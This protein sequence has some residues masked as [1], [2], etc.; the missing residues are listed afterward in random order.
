MLE[1]AGIE[2]V[3]HARDGAAALAEIVARSP[4]VAVL[5]V[6]MPKHSGIEIAKHVSATHPSTAVLLYTGYAERAMVT[7]ALDSGTRGF[8][9]KEAP[10]HDLVRAV[11]T[12]ARGDTYVDAVLAGVI[13]GA[14]DRIPSLSPREREI[15]RLLS[16]GRSNSEVG[17]ELTIST[18]TVRTHVRRAM[19]KLESNTRTQAVATA[20]RLAIIT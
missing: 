8:A 10:L 16:N 6:R 12:V 2:V 20:L 5:D 13:A 11:E 19:Q 14:A 3:A 1:A 17:R 15:L 9:L 4:Q 7:E 18:E